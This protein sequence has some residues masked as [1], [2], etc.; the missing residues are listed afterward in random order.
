MISR[1]ICFTLLVVDEF[2]VKYVGK[3]NADHLIG[4]LRALYSIAI[5]WDGTLS[6]GFTFK[7]N[8]KDR[9]RYVDIS[10]PG[11]VAKALHRF[12]HGLPRKPQDSP[13]PWTKPDYGCKVQL[14]P[15]PDTTTPLDADGKTRL[16][17]IVGTL[18][19]YA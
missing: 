3:E 12:Q 10:M 8:Y 13:Y 9:Y 17:E 2:G 15:P 18:L 1:D 6:C 5:D 11:Y 4:A 7:W 14:S 19:Y 16:Q